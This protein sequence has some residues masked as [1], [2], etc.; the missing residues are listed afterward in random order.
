MHRL[1]LDHYRRRWWVLALVAVL[2][3]RLGWFIAAHPTLPCEFW[4]FALVLWMGAVLLSFDL[5]HGLIRVVVPLPL[6]PRQ[7]GRSWWLATVAIPALALPLLLFSGA[8]TCCQLHPNTVLPAQQLAVASAFGLVWLGVSFTLIFNATRGI[9]ENG[10]EVATNFLINVLA[11]VTFFASMLL[12]SGISQSPLKSALLL[13]LGGL[14]TVV[15]WVRANQFEPDRA[16]PYLGRP[17]QF[18]PGRF[19]RRSPGQAGARLTPLQLK[20]SPGESRVPAGYGGIAF[21]VSTGFVRMFWYVAAMIALLPLVTRLQ[22]SEG[23]EFPRDMGIWLFSATMSYLVCGFIVIFQL[24]PTLRQLRFL[25]TLPVS[26]TRLAAAMLSLMVLPLLGVGAL[27]AGVAGYCLGA[28]AALTIL[29]HC[30]FILAPASLCVF[31]AAWLGEGVLGYALLVL[32]VFGF[33]QGYG[34]MQTHFH[35]RGLPF[36]LVSAI[37]AGCLVL[38]FVLTRYALEH[39]ARAYRVRADTSGQF[40][41]GIGG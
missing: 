31:F 37:A 15:G 1:I 11:A 32:A 41:W 30:L 19:R 28:A 24:L 7:I 26:T 23:V 25:R 5:K 22:R 20:T 8:A 3:F 16:W 29:N 6:T 36:P 2:V 13:G 35:F 9:G 39:D 10:L 14:L 40:P 21:L 17:G 18:G 34:L 33:Q 38:A 27:V 12:A 4:V